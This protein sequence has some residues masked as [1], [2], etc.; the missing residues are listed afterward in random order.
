MSRFRIVAAAAALALVA[1]P[2]FAQGEGTR[3]ASYAQKTPRPMVHHHAGSS[4]MGHGGA[5]P[6]SA[7]NMADQLNAQVLS[8]IAAGGTP[9]PADAGAPAAPMK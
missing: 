1:A 7:D 8:S 9:T 5:S 3:S 2:A 4:K 6:S